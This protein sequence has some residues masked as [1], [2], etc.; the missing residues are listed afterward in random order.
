[1]SP[2]RRLAILPLLLAAAHAA[3]AP[4][5]VPPETAQLLTAIAD[6]EPAEALRRLSDYH[7]PEHALVALARGQ[8]RWRL[9]QRAEAE[10]DFAAALKLDPGLRQ[11]QLGLAQCAAAREDWP[12]ATRAAAAALE[13]GRSDRGLIVFL[14]QAALRAGDWRLATL[15]AQEGILRFPEDDALR[16]VELAVL[17]NAGRAE[18]ARQAALALLSRH[19]EDA[20]LW[21]HLAWSA[22][23]SGRED[24]A[25]AAREA[26]LAMRPDDRA[27]RRQLAE[28]QMG[29]GMP[30]AALLTV[31]PLIGDPPSATAL[32][33]AP[34]MLLACRAAADAG[35]ADRARAW[36]AAV[37]ESTRD[38]ALRLLDARLSVQAGDQAAA[39]AALEALIA[40]G[41]RDAAVL[42]WAAALAEQRGDAAR[43]EA[44]FLQAMAGD[45]GA[46]A[47]LRLAAL[48]IRQDRRDEAAGVLATHLARHPEDTQARALQARLAQPAA[49][50]ARQP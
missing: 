15:A 12:A 2:I 34:L 31:S 18:D 13:P 50:S 21:G 3:D 4:R 19:P 9:E 16:R 46:A 41:E 32:G 39:A 48:Y 36:L 30:Q 26:A 14:A 35:E 37:P 5:P 1:M 42:T 44:L 25:L 49:R 33:D 23:A 38:R 40:L 24:E 47:A 22:Q 45:G 6:A 27:L 43:A 20:G 7:G 8:A 11:A 29:R 10:A 28:A 17:A